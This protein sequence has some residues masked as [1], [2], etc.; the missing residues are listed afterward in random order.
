MKKALRT[1]SEIIEWSRKVLKQT[2]INMSVVVERP[3]SSVLKISTPQGFVYLKQTPHDLF[4]EV[5]IIKK[6]RNLCKITNIPEV[7]AENKNLNCFLMKEC[8][9]VSLRTFF[10]GHLNV[11]LFV[12]ALQVYKAMQ[13]ATEP[14]VD[15]FLQL[16]VP[17]W[18][19]LHFPKLY[20]DLVGD[21]FFLKAHGLETVQIKTLQ[22]SLASL[23]VLC[24][25]LESYAIPASL[26]HSDFHDNNMLFS[27]ATKKISI[28][29]LGE[30]AITHPF[31]TLAAFLKIP[32]DNYHLSVSSPGYQA[33]HDTCFKGW[34]VSDEDL[35]KALALTQ[36][37]LPIYL[38][39]AH[40]RLVNATCATKI[41]T[42]PKMKN[43]IKEGLLWF[44]KNIGAIC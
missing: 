28:I 26:N 25:E 6:Y 13:Q 12:Q 3:W 27:H 7:I 4:I 11:D 40:M 37:L 30:T 44:M 14:H 5:E 32:S 29:D 19:L 34:L 15:T 22:D 10:N 36:K 18:R 2:E 39:F 31:F 1:H 41:A 17:D 8:G 42:I 16:G 24:Q 35:N 20:Q 9:D 43:R 38:I 33:L 23:E 21:E